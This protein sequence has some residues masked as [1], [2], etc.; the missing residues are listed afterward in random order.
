MHRGVAGLLCLAALGCGDDDA[1]TPVDAGTTAD[2]RPP[3][4][5]GGADAGATMDTLT[6]TVVDALTREPLDAVATAVDTD[7]GR[8][9]AISGADGMVSIPIEYRDPSLTLV[10]AKSGYTIFAAVD[11]TLDQVRAAIATSD[12][13]LTLSP[14]SPTGPPPFRFS[15][16]PS[17]VPAG[18]RACVSAFGP[19]W[20][21]L[22]ANE[23]ETIARDIE[24]GG[25][26]MPNSEVT[27]FALD[28]DDNVVDFVT[29]PPMVDGMNVTAT[30]AFDGTPD[31]TPVVR[32][33]TLELPEGPLRTDGV[34]DIDHLVAALDPE[35]NA[36]RS[37][38]TQRMRA[39]DGS[40]YTMTHTAFPHPERAPAHA[41]AAFADGHDYRFFVRTVRRFPGDLPGDTISLRAGPTI[42][43]GPTVHDPMSW[44]SPTGDDASYYM[45]RINTGGGA[46]IW[47]VAATSTEITLPQL[48]SGYDPETSYPFPGSGAR[49]SVDAFHGPV[50]PPTPD[51][52][53]ER[54]IAN[55]PWVE[56]TF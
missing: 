48:P 18:G 30:I 3:G 17:G 52:T 42:T 13:E 33:L 9:E 38:T 16:T 6:F 36:I 28:A 21:F 1:M 27:A 31:S 10:N 54:E 49:A 7:V 43:G 51:L 24:S 12:G 41:I 55:G 47:F 26:N 15:V 45:L 11:L 39:A 14:V 35:T 34:T 32:T 29:A 46:P 5:S 40:S 50:W 20:F 4:D 2:S 23:G 22:C 44:T 56:L 8:F 19:G 37:I 53:E 25:G